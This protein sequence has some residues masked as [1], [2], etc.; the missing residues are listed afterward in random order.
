MA[1]YVHVV[2]LSY[3]VI[4]GN[5]ALG[6]TCQNPQVSSE[7]YTTTDATVVV[8]IA[9]IAQF[10][11]KCSNNVKNLNLYADVNGKI[12]PVTK[13]LEENKYQV[14]WTEDPKKVSSGEHQ[15][16]IYDEEGFALLRKAQRNGEDTSNLKPSFT[17]GVNHHGTYTGPWVQSEFMA[18]ATAL[19]VWYLA[20]SAKSKI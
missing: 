19:V 16:K 20:Y 6:D 13:S 18:A 5:F 9:F 14:S 10:T 4:L 7:S 2:L 17:I 1:N 3:F 12:I 15:V 8:N 11:V